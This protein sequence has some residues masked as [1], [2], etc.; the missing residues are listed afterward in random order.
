M[1]RVKGRQASLISVC[2]KT[3]DQS[4]LKKASFSTQDSVFKSEDAEEEKRR[5]FPWIGAAEPV[6]MWLRRSYSCLLSLIPTKSDLSWFCVLLHSESCLDLLHMSKS[7]MSKSTLYWFGR[8][9]ESCRSVYNRGMHWFKQDMS[10]YRW[11]TRYHRRGCIDCR[12]GFGRFEVCHIP[13]SGTLIFATKSRI[14]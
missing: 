2:V 9:G 10:R 1:D 6:Q 11:G 7:T 12:D 4:C 5:G 3:A 8:Q 13:A 14:E